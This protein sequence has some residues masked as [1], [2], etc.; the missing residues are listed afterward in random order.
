[1]R[2]SLIVFIAASIAV[3]SAGSAAP[4]VAP[5]TPTTPTQFKKRN[6]GV[7]LGS[8]SIGVG[9]RKVTKKEKTYERVNYTAVS[10]ERQWRSAKGK[11]ITASLLAF[12]NGQVK[13]HKVP[14]TLIKEG[15]VRVLKRGHFKPHLFPLELL[16]DEDQK[17]VRALGRV[18]RT[19]PELVLVWAC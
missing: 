2:L 1:M 19:R 6:L 12:E 16:S 10:P 18:T 3:L 14:L 8:Q 9:T 4:P 17:Y 15:K 7:G 13:D 11:A 5:V